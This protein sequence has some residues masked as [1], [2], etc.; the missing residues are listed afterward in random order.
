MP[1]RY[2]MGFVTGKW[3]IF[4]TIQ[5]PAVVL[6]TALR[7]W[8]KSR[9]LPIPKLLSVPFTLS[10]LLCMGHFFFFPP[11]TETPLSARVL[12]NLQTSFHHVAA[13]LLLSP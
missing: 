4:F 1:Y 7:K 5:G 3:Q 11:C 8:L 10:L 12:G 2:L 13:L 9:R 6:E